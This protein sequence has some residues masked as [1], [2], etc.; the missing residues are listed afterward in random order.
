MTEKR[1]RTIFII[2]FSV[3]LA[4]TLGLIWGNSV[5]DANKSADQSSAVY[6]EVKTATTTVVGE[7]RAEEFFSRFTLKDFRKLAHVIEYFVLS[8]EVACL[9]CVIFGAKKTTLKY[10]PVSILSG[11]FT[12]VIDETVQI[13][14]NRGS[15]VA[16]VWVDASGYVIGTLVA[17]VIIAIAVSVGKK[18]ETARK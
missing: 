16:D 5:R 15:S 18:R 3:L 13:F 8:I 6:E 9:F 17:T 14:S 4:F 2:T 10:L 7:E 12:A 1:R 11:I